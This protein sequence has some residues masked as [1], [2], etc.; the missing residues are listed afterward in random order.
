MAIATHARDD[1][2]QRLEAALVDQDRLEG[3]YRAA[4]GT[5]SEFTAYARL[6]AASDDVSA[7][8]A[9]L[10]SIDDD[11]PGGGRVWVNGREVGGTD[12][13]FLGLEDSHD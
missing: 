6:H 13:L 12:S 9:W 1:A 3:R 10:N 8:E 11:G 7:R 5:S 4:L 2:V